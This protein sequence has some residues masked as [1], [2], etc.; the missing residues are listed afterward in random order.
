MRKC[1]VVNLHGLPASCMQQVATQA[2][3]RLCVPSCLIKD[4]EFELASIYRE[5]LGR[6]I[7]HPIPEFYQRIISAYYDQESGLSCQ[8]RVVITI[9]SPITWIARLLTC[10][11]DLTAHLNEG[12]IT[13]LMQFLPAPHIVR[14]PVYCTSLPKEIA[15]KYA[16]TSPF[17]P[18]RTRE[19]D[20]KTMEIVRHY[21]KGP[22]LIETTIQERGKKLASLILDKL[23]GADML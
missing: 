1:L 11:D 16:P 5:V 4:F 10:G 15:E 14:L 9:N 7:L 21:C 22:K 20:G 12:E 8:T 3:E 19:W 6:R 13:K 17:V 2:Q 18:T 23:I